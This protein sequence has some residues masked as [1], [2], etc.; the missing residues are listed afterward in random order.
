M[1]IF[2]RLVIAA[3]VVLGGGFLTGCG[4]KADAAVEKQPEAMVEALR[5]VKGVLAI[6]SVKH[7]KL[8][9]EDVNLVTGKLVEEGVPEA[10]MA[11]LLLGQLSRYGYPNFA[12]ITQGTNVGVVML[13]DLKEMR[14][15]AKPVWVAMVQFDPEVKRGALKRLLRG[16]VETGV[17]AVKEVGKWTLVAQDE[18]NFEKLKDWAGIETFLA[19]PQKELVRAFS[20]ASEEVVGF[21][22]GVVKEELKKAKMDAELKGNLGEYAKVFFEMA[23][24]VHSGGWSLAF[25]EEGVKFDSAL[26]FKPE[27]RLGTFFRYKMGGEEV[28]SAKFVSGEDA[29]LTMIG[30]G[31]PVV[32]A[33][34]NDYVVDELAKVGSKEVS[35]W[36]KKFQVSA[37]KWALASDGKY[38]GVMNMEGWDVKNNAPKMEMFAVYSGNYTNEI[39]KEYMEFSAGLMDALF[40]KAADG[41]KK[42]NDIEISLS[43]RPDVLEVEGIKFGALDTE[44][45]MGGKKGQQQKTAQFAGVVKGAMVMSMD[46]ASLRGRVPA[47][48]AGMELE[49]SVAKL[50]SLAPYQIADFKVHGAGILR[51]TETM[52]KTSG[53]GAKWDEAKEVLEELRAAYAAGEAARGAVFVRQAR[54]ESESVVPYKFIATTIRLVKELR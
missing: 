43:Y 10:G 16:Q 31:D 20:S 32:G 30:C 2:T 11:G 53:Q 48:K 37:K 4:K 41:K 42:K 5:E 44:V 21:L 38:T 29:L 49:K 26:Q 19:E 14:E 7:P 22:E 24:Q 17:L 54:V 1:K 34:I 50:H 28:P 35:E 9:G 33:K 25:A 18:G 45:K 46:E 47:L 36:L 6:Y 13:G 39:V 51:T 12:E 27:S 52:M 40:K 15:G 3:V 23:K 8:I